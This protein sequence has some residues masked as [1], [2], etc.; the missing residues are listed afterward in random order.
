MVI[1]NECIECMG[2]RLDSACVSKGHHK[3]TKTGYGFVL[4]VIYL[5]NKTK[6]GH[7]N[8]CLGEIFT[9]F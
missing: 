6:I 9:I 5:Q 3:N 2:Y 4:M 7:K 1:G 8:S